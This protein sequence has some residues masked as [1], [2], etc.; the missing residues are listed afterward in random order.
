MSKT[1]PCTDDVVDDGRCAIVV[2][3]CVMGCALAFPVVLCCVV[4]W[5]G[6]VCCFAVVCCVVVSGYVVACCDDVVGCLMVVR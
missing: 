2:A 3:D 6:V 5:F 1:I 4:A